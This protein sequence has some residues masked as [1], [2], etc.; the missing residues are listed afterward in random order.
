MIPA[1]SIAEA[2]AK[3]KELLGK[4]NATI[5]AIPDGVSVV[6]SK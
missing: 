4:E 6:V 5:T 3:A 2:I 1:H